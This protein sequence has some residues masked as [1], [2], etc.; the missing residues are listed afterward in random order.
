MVP[1]NP[2][3]RLLRIGHD[4]HDERRI[5]GQVQNVKNIQQFQ[6]YMEALK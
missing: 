2:F 6:C 4:P 1:S 3:V 5:K